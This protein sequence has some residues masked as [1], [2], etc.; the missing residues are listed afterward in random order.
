M[1]DS[2]TGQERNESPTPRR[3]QEAREEG[4]VARSVEVS[5]AA[6][7]LAGAAALSTFCGA[8][9]AQ[10]TTRLLRESARSLSTGGLTPAGAVLLVRDATGGFLLALLPFLMI[11]TASTVF[12]NLLQT[13]GLLTA[14]PL[15]PKWSNI[16][17]MTGIRRLTGLDSLFNLLKS[18]L[19]LGVL[20][21]LTWIA[22]RKSWPQLVSLAE[23]GPIEIASVLKIVI[24]RLVM[25]AGISFL[26]IALLDYGFQRFQTE[27]RLR[28]TRQEVI[29]ENRES[30]GDPNVKSR[31]RSMAQAQARKRMLQKVP[32]ADVVVVNP[33]QIAVALRYDTAIAAAPVVVAMG[34]RKLAERIKKIALASDVPVVENRPVARALLATAKVGHPI[35]PALYAAVAEILAFIFRTR[36]RLRALTSDALLPGRTS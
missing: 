15:M 11:L 35:P 34:E 6:I 36:G 27:R 1:A 8:S 19:K 20:S 23:A 7:L 10:Y 25:T 21:L 28:M 4:R 31:L 13:Q 33:T 32:M 24:V 3:R 18:I 29:L 30:E 14:K 22:I 2:D 9:I 26:G 5:T 12:V 16:D 17:P